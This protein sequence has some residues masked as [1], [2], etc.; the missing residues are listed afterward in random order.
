MTYDGNLPLWLTEDIT[1]PILWGLL[2]LGLFF[3]FWFV[4]K[5]NRHLLGV[6]AVGGFLVTAVIV[7][8]RFVTDKEFLVNAIVTMSDAVR[9]NDAEA[10]VQFVRDDN[11]VFKNR[12]RNNMSKYKFSHCRLIGFNQTDV[13]QSDS[14]PQTAEM[15][16]A[17]WAT[18]AFANRPDSFH[19]ANVKVK[20]DFQKSNGRWTI[21]GYGYQP[22]NDTGKIS[23]ISN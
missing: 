3:L 17:V 5:Q 8:Q 19:S 20:L 1:W 10:I 2:A 11:E 18:G 6:L 7:E 9:E 22:S 16:F 4:T 12:I 21:E 23:M 15:G 13:D 14:Q